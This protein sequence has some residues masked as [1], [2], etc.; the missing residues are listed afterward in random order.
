MGRHSVITGSFDAASSRHP[1]TVPPAAVIPEPARSYGM[2]ATLGSRRS[3][4]AVVAVVAGGIATAA[5]PLVYAQQPGE[6]LAPMV[7]S[8]GAA[9]VELVRGAAQRLSSE[10]PSGIS[11]PVP[12]LAVVPEVAPV[13]SG[14]TVSTELP[15]LRKAV[16]EGRRAAES[17]GRPARAEPARPRG[18]ASAASVA[19]F[20]RPVTGRITSNYGP[21]W[22]TT[23][24]GLDIANRIGT[25]VRSVGAGTVV[26]A[27]PASGFG[28]WVRVR[29]A[30]GTMTVYGHINRAL[31]RVGQRVDAGDLIAEVGNRGQ[32]T[33]PHLHFET[34]AAD[35]RR[36]DPLAWL[37]RRG[38]GSI[39]D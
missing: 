37:E 1:S 21:R 35:G 15:A 6:D 32:S 14:G 33:G 24:Y 7:S 18:Q 23:H 38:A 39:V 34:I 17:A 29:L 36:M 19:G 4:A 16:T 27:G 5:L 26:S 20:V 30:D 3:T 8:S 11:Q 10:A 28:L 13:P 22:G 9:V 25:P 12:G 2:A 31:V